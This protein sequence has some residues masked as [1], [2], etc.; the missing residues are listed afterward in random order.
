MSSPQRMRMLGLRDVAMFN[1]VSW[2][3]D[4]ARF[5]RSGWKGRSGAGF[6]VSLH[7]DAYA[8]ARFASSFCRRIVSRLNEGGT[9]ANLGTAHRGRNTVIGE[10]R[11]ALSG[12]TM[13]L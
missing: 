13:C 1:S 12:R 10:R 6:D 3:M 2:G 5:N 11:D 7:P 9:P 4:D 8:V